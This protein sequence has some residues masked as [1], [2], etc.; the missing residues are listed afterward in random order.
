MSRRR[1]PLRHFLDRYQ[2]AWLSNGQQRGIYRLTY[3]DKDDDHSVHS[4]F[5]DTKNGAMRI[6]MDIQ[7]LDFR[8]F[9]L[10]WQNIYIYIYIMVCYSLLVSKQYKLIL[11]LSWSNLIHFLWNSNS[12][13]NRRI[14][15]GW[16]K[17]T[18][19]STACCYDQS[20]F[21]YGF[22]KMPYW[23]DC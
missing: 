3:N 15:S 2:M 13:W 5:N 7:N 11:T 12:L 18:L 14:N 4:E 10:N 6:L 9:S 1:L 17:E 23:L 8:Y 20:H 19:L 16:L 22:G 21:I